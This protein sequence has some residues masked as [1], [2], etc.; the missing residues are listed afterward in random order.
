M[1]KEDGGIHVDDWQAI[2]DNELKQHAEDWDLDAKCRTG[3]ISEETPDEKRRNMFY[4]V[5]RHA[6]E[7]M[8]SSLIHVKDFDLV[9][10]C[11]DGAARII[12]EIAKRAGEEYY[13]KP[14]DPEF[15]DALYVDEL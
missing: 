9:S 15:N 10:Q 13:L 2:S 3:S 12:S 6:I 1:S 5:N 14:S 7:G 8:A 11:I 4:A